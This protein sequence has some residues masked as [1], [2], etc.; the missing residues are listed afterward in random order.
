[1]L[2]AITA[3][4]AHPSA[5]RLAGVPL[6]EADARYSPFAP[7]RAQPA[8]PGLVRS[9]AADLLL[10]HEEKLQPGIPPRSVR[11]NRQRSLEITASNGLRCI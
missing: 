2:L 4:H 9:V 1:M 11:I 10:V 7:R 6:A 5:R 3:R 8:V